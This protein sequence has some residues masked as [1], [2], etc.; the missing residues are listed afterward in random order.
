MLN[1][2]R[3]RLREAKGN[4]LIELA[5]VLPLMVVLLG[6]SI[7]L[8]RAFYTYNI[9]TKSV[10]NAA[11]YLSATQISPAGVI[12]GQYVTRAQN[13]SIYGNVA[14]SG[15]KIIPDLGSADITVSGVATPGGSPN[16]FYV[17]VSANYAYTPLFGF[18]L[19]DVTFQ[20]KVTMVFVGVITGT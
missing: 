17:T 18:V 20:P 16:E 5:L 4:E 8:G 3:S 15:T 14:G 6:G 13:L 10:R 12:P 19:S 9:L 2:R 1:K 11:R 7:E